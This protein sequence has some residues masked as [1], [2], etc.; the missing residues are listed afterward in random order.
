M[1]MAWL[2]AT[3]PF[4]IG[5][6]LIGGIILQIV[7]SN[8]KNRFLGLIIPSLT[9]I[10]ITSQFSYFIYRIGGF[11]IRAIFTYII[12]L[13]QLN[14]PTIVLILIYGYCRYRIGKKDKVDKM[15]IQ[16]L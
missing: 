4:I 9:F 6:I 3:L 11:D 10:L 15:N 8:K 2:I 14:I 5:L 16:D 13:V 7:L 1:S 12:M